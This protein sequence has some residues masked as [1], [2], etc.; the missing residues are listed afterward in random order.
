MFLVS[1]SI[2]NIFKNKLFCPVYSHIQLFWLT[3]VKRLS[4]KGN[5]YDLFRLSAAIQIE[6]GTEATAF[7]P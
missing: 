3:P 2:H 4:A 1:V 5:D 6:A 7:E